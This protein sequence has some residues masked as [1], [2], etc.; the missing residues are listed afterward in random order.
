MEERRDS[1]PD[2]S[3]LRRENDNEAVLRKRVSNKT[4]KSAFV[5]ENKI[6]SDLEDDDI[7]QEVNISVW[8]IKKYFEYVSLVLH[9]ERS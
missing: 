1:N 3:V 4:S 6:D 2:S 5:D 9:T 8:A 7:S